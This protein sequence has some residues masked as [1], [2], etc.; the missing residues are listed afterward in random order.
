VDPV[1]FVLDTD[2]ARQRWQLADGEAHPVHADQPPYRVGPR[3]ESRART[4]SRAGG[5]PADVRLTRSTGCSRR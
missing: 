5:R 3:A 1:A 4:A 2:H